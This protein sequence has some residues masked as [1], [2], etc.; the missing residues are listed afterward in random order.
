M[1]KLKQHRFSF[2]NK[3]KLKLDSSQMSQTQTPLK[4]PRQT[5]AQT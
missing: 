4:Q 1:N 3:L 5:R 2:K